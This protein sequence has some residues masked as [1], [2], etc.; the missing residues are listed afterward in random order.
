MKIGRKQKQDY[1]KQSTTRLFFIADKRLVTKKISR[2]AQQ[3]S[4]LEQNQRFCR[5][6]SSNSEASSS[7]SCRYVPTGNLQLWSGC[8]EDWKTWRNYI[9]CTY[10]IQ[11]QYLQLYWEISNIHKIIY[12][13]KRSTHTFKH[14]TIF[15][16]YLAHRFP[17]KLVRD[18]LNTCFILLNHFASMCRWLHRI[19][20]MTVE[21]YKNPKGMVGEI[22]ALGLRPILSRLGRT[23]HQS[24]VWTERFKRSHSFG[25]GCWKIARVHLVRESLANSFLRNF[26]SS[27][28]TEA[29][30]WIDT[31]LSGAQTLRF[32]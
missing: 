4:T 17:S 9:Y 1:F 11:Y 8:G 5:C 32:S 6:R 13:I 27:R 18:R 14:I 15:G 7:S 22:S 23:E 30:F 2:G 24:K 29:M 31:N 16:F 19:I 25:R 28:G 20:E 10:I 3:P 12:R 21:M 26:P